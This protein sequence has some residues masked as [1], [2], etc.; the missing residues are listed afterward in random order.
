MPRERWRDHI[1]GFRFVV[2]D[3]SPNLN[4]PF[5]VLMPSIGCA[6]VSGI[7]LEVET[8]QNRPL[9]S[10]YSTPY[11]T[12]AQVNPVTFERGARADDTDFYRWVERSI[13][14]IDQFRRNLLVIQLMPGNQ[15]P[16]GL[17][18]SLSVGVPIPG[19]TKLP[20]RSWILW[21][22]IPTN[23]TPGDLDAS[24]GDITM[25][26]LTVQPHAFTEVAAGALV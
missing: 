25:L 1:G 5:F 18:G 15:L 17:G 22:C 9:N 2:C 13:N 3:I 16:F 6:R 4:P 14:G 20:A 19:V 12:G 7:G 26:S 11:V 24:S 10:H 8:E 23:Y 21:D